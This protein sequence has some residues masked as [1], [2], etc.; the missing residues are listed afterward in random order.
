MRTHAL[1]HINRMRIHVFFTHK[2]D[3]STYAFTH[4]SDDNACVFT[5]KSEKR[6]V[7]STHKSDELFNNK[8]KKGL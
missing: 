7:Y 3:D 1:L 8:S 2:S 6:V 5:H 4:K